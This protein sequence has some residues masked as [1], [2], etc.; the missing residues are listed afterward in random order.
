MVWPLGFIPAGLFDA[1]PHGNDA[2]YTSFMRWSRS[3]VISRLV[4]LRRGCLVPRASRNASLTRRRARKMARFPSMIA[5][6]R[7]RRK[8]SDRVMTVVFLYGFTGLA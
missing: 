4:I 8:C 5:P 6:I 1:V 3:S 7:C 2:P